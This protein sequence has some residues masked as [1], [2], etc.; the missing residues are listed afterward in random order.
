[1]QVVCQDRLVKFC[2]TF[3]TMVQG[4]WLLQLTASS[5][6]SPAWAVTLYTWHTAAIFL[7]SLTALAVCDKIARPSAPL[8]N[9]VSVSEIKMKK[10]KKLPDPDGQRVPVG[11][12]YD[13]LL[14]GRSGATTRQPAGPPQQ[15]PAQRGGC[16]A[17]GQ[18]AAC[19]FQ[20]TMISHPAL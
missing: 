4:S 6:A 15:R 7:A 2:R 1:M 20:Q 13:G 18:T 19:N 12:L 3:F 10:K 8:H 14:A 5:P 11:G 16:R 17:L 9:Q